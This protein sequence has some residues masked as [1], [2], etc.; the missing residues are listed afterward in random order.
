MVYFMVESNDSTLN[1]MDSLG[2]RYIVLQYHDFKT[3]NIFL[4]DLGIILY[5]TNN[6]KE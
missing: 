5:R 2:D 3:Q 1:K 4:I 6:R